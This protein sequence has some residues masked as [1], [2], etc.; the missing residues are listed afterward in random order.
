MSKDGGVAPGGAYAS[1][2]K[3]PALSL[4]AQ[5]YVLE[6]SLVEALGGEVI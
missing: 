4:L 1:E 3:T 5:H 2:K 6:A